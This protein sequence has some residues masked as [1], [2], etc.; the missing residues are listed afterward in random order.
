VEES[1]VFGHIATAILVETDADV[2]DCSPRLI[3]APYSFAQEFP[4]RLSICKADK[5]VE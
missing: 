1:A 4:L 2:V 3:I 5:A